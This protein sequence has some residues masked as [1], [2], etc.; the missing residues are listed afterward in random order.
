MSWDANWETSIHSRSS[1]LSSNDNDVSQNLY[2]EWFSPQ[3]YPVP[4][5]VGEPMTLVMREKKVQRT[6]ISFLNF[7]IFCVR[8][9]RNFWALSFEQ[10]YKSRK[11]APTP[12][13]LILMIIFF[14]LYMTCVLPI[15][16]GHDDER[17]RITHKHMPNG[18]SRVR[19][20]DAHSRKSQIFTKPVDSVGE[21]PWTCV[22]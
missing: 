14:F 13:R 2:E 8:L 19:R 4:M 7:L 1:N 16:Y 15:A 6:C 17:R 18:Q 22:T 10:E 20:S 11:S 12:S 5:P 9:R 3:A 21:R